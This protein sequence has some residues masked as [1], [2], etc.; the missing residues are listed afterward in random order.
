MLSGESEIG[1][2]G[3]D[4]PVSK[5]HRDWP[6]KKGTGPIVSWRQKNGPLA[7]FC[8]PTENVVISDPEWSARWVQQ[9]IIP[10]DRQNIG[11]ILRD[12]GLREYQA[13]RLLVLGEGRCA[14]DDCS[15]M[16]IKDRQLPEWIAERRK[17][18]L[19]LAVPLSSS[20][21]TE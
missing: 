6:R 16:P 2:Q 13:Y 8:F 14:Q 21:A 5:G 1:G 19:E 9:R 20:C 3:V 7:P 11:T 17:K 15:V 4:S 18:K 12:N 10:A